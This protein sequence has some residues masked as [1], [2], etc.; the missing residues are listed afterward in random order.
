VI[1][2][3]GSPVVGGYA[4]PLALSSGSSANTLC[5]E[6]WLRAVPTVKAA[7]AVFKRDSSPL[8]QGLEYRPIQMS[9][10]A[11][12]S[13]FHS[14]FGNRIERVWRDRNVVVS[15]VVYSLSQRLRARAGIQRFAISTLAD[16]QDDSQAGG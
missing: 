13:A 1:T 6:L 8:P 10:I 15:I 5:A 3:P 7:R 9:T 16:S 11:D 12:Q 2:H 14:L 4:G